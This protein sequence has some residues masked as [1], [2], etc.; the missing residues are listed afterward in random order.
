MKGERRK[1]KGLENNE[2]RMGGK[3]KKRGNTP[4]GAVTCLFS[5]S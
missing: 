5:E 4:L 2:P 1:V 3:E